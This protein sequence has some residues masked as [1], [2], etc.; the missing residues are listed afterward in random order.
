VRAEQSGEESLGRQVFPDKWVSNEEELSC[1][2]K[3]YGH[4]LGGF[5]ENLT[6]AWATLSSGKS[7][8]P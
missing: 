4:F 3:G 5:K 8:D 1:Q 2:D 7:L 6:Q